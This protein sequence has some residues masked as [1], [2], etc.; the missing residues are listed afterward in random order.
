MRLRFGLE[1]FNDV[2]RIWSDE[3]AEDSLIDSVS[4]EPLDNF[5]SIGFHNMSEKRNC[6]D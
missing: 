4:K 2:G 5:N 1:K 6:A 3:L